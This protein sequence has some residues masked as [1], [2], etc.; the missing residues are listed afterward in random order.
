MGAEEA[1][2]YIKEFHKNK[3]VIDLPFGSG[4]IIRVNPCCRNLV[5]IIRDC[6]NSIKKCVTFEKGE[7]VVDWKKAIHIGYSPEI[8]YAIGLAN[9]LFELGVLSR[10]AKGNYGV[11]FPPN[12]LMSLGIGDTYFTREKDADQ[13]LEI[14]SKSSGMMLTKIKFQ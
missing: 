1:L 13:Y 10:T 5:K 14:E 3:G 12:I 9:Y 7:A 6:E 11:F 4:Q 8:D 2:E